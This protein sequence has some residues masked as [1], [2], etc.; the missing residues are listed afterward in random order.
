MFYWAMLFLICAIVLAILGFGV[1]A[2]AAAAVA[3]ILFYV[4]VAI[5]IISLIAGF[6]RRRPAV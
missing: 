5:F 4:F 2:S 3:K 1:L 6:F